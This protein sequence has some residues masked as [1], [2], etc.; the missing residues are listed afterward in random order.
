MKQ[1]RGARWAG[2]TALAG[3][4]GLVLAPG[5]ASA[6]QPHPWQLGFQEAATPLMESVVSLHNLLLVIISVITAFV[7]LLMLY[8]VIRYNSRTN[9][10]PT[11]TSHNTVLEILWTAVPVLILLVIAIPSFRLLFQSDIIPEAD[12]TVKAT[13][14]QWYW[15]YEYPDHGAFAFDAFLVE[16]EDL[17]PGQPRL[18]ATDNHIVVPVGAVVRLQVTASDVLHAWA[19]PAFGVKIDAVPGR[20]NETWFQVTEP[21]L[22]YGQCSELCGV[23]HGYMPITVEAVSPAAF[24]AWVAETQARLLPAESLPDDAD[25]DA[26][27]RLASNN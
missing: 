8:V 22:Y 9:R 6:A 1:F 17:Q 5:A 16:D 20:L 25:T 27:V 13:G 19:V 12:M 18:L 7:A 23:R 21:G 14:H 4:A 3:L 10:E 2:L 11:R 26:A 15:S 24:D